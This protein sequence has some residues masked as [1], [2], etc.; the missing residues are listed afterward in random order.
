MDGTT[1]NNPFFLCMNF[2]FDNKTKPEI[3][4]AYFQCSTKFADSKP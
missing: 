1:E 3:R 2:P 4:P